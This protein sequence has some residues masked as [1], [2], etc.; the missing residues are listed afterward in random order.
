MTED[1]FTNGNVRRLRGSNGPDELNHLYERCLKEVD[2][3]YRGIF[4]RQHK[5]RRFITGKTTPKQAALSGEA[6]NKFIQFMRDDQCG[7][8]ASL[9]LS[10]LEMLD[11]VA[12]AALRGKVLRFRNKDGVA[13]DVI[14]EG[15]FDEPVAYPEGYEPPD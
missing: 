15:G 12:N 8:L 11:I 6:A 2:E 7:A 13:T 14:I 9:G 3:K 1:Q 10:A 5:A 4:G